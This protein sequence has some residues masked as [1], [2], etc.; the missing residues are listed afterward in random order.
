MDINQT[1]YHSDHDILNFQGS[2]FRR[3]QNRGRV[4]S[5]P[6]EIIAMTDAYLACCEIHDVVHAFREVHDVFGEEVSSLG[7]RM[8]SIFEC[9]KPEVL[10]QSERIAV[11]SLSSP[12]VYRAIRQG[13]RRHL[14]YGELSEATVERL[15]EEIQAALTWVVL[16][17]AAQSK[18]T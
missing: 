18:E 9:Y 10:S 8:K 1:L 16:R 12:Q 15:C 2:L 7:P 17:R 3:S 4:L 14:A 5:T 13:G 11:K 6:G